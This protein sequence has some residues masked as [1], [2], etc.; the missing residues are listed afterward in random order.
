M[1]HK[2]KSY[3]PDAESIIEIGFFVMSVLMT[4]VCLAAALAG[5]KH[6]W[7]L[8]AICAVLS[9]VQFKELKKGGE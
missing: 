3:V 1:E 2:E 9:V 5:A 7:L 8:V 6:Q 4:M